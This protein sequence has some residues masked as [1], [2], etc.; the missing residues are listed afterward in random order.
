M[1]GW[2]SSSRRWAP[3]PRRRSETAL[4]PLPHRVDGCSL[5]RGA[6]GAR[7]VICARPLGSHLYAHYRARGFS[8]RVVR[9]DYRFESRRAALGTLGFFFGKG[10]ARRAEALLADVAD[11]GEACFVPECTGVWWRV[12]H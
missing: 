9:T 12:K 1:G 10:V 8:Q 11:D 6:G 7:G 2:P 5:S 3:R 4:S